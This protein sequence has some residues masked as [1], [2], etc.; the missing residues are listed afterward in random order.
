MQALVKNIDWGCFTCSRVAV[1][2]PIIAPVSKALK[3]VA[4]TVEVGLDSPVA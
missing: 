3:G 1:P 4:V 2:V